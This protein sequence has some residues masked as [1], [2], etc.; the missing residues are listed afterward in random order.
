[1][2]V[3]TNNNIRFYDMD[4]ETR[5]E[6]WKIGFE[7]YSQWSPTQWVPSFVKSQ[8]PIETKDIA[9]GVKTR[10]KEVLK[11]SETTLKKE[12]MRLLAVQAHLEKRSMDLDS[13]KEESE[14]M[15]SI[16]M[17]ESDIPLIYK[18]L[19]RVTVEPFVSPSGLRGYKISF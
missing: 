3:K 6:P 10:F 2:G 5:Y 4:E 7:L 11:F 16:S 13:L 15:R 8:R 17:L 19:N 1:M 9:Q 18:K 12:K 14:L